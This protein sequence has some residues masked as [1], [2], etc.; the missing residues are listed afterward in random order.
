MPAQLHPVVLD[1]ATA[2]RVHAL[3]V[4]VLEQFAAVAARSH[5]EAIGR[6]IGTGY[7]LFAGEG[8][9]ITQVYGFAYRSPGDIGELAAFY[10]SRCQSWEVSITPFTD[11]ETVA[12]LH[13]AG[14]RPGA[15]EGELAMWIGDV[16]E[17]ERR[18]EEVD[19]SDPA[20]QETTAQA[21]LDDA[22]PPGQIARPPFDPII[23][24]FAATSARKYLAFDDGVPAASAIMW[25][26]P[27]GVALAGGATRKSARGHGLQ[28]ALLRRRLRDAGTG[29]FAFVGATPGAIS[30]RNAMR[31]GFTPLYSTIAFRPSP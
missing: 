4:D 28:A 21:W 13:A 29:R 14:Y 26:R 23:D 12:A 7:A 17:P 24:V 11:A 27:Q 8:S 3:N 1:D 15:F 5:P 9:P 25:D 16:P 22:S 31:V 6:R 20:W 10:A 19:G 18:V 30:Y 2:D